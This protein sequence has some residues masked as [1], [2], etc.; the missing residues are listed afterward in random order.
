MV[1]WEL[2]IVQFEGVSHGKRAWLFTCMAWEGL[3]LTE[4]GFF[5]DFSVFSTPL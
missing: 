4:S 5:G 2:E 3:V 1:L